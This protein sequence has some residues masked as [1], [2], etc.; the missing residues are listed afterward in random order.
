MTVIFFLVS[1]VW[2]RAE[3][4]KMRNFSHFLIAH[5]NAHLV[6]MFRGLSVNPSPSVGELTV[7]FCLS[8]RVVTNLSSKNFN[9]EDKLELIFHFLIGMGA[10][11]WTPKKKHKQKKSN[12]SLKRNAFFFK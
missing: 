6:N 12:Q 9:G 11:G 8:A 1:R 5:S 7:P 3:V 4:L 2:F 10:V